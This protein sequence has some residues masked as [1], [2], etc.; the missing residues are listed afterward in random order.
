MFL[1]DELVATLREAKSGALQLV[2]AEDVLD[3]HRGLPL[4]SCSLPVLNKPQDAKNFLDGVLP[5]GAFRAQLA[6]NAGVLATD[7]FGLLNRY[8]RDIAGAIS[9]EAT[10]AA[11]RTGRQSLLELDDD[12]LAA[13]VMAIPDQPLGIHDDSE[14]S[15]AGLQNKLLLVKHGDRWARPVGGMA[16]THI[17]KLDSQSHPGVV[18]AEAEVMGLAKAVG[19]TTVEVERMTIGGIECIAVERFDRTVRADGVVKRIHQEDVCQAL[20][21]PPERK[22]EL[23]GRGRPGHGGGPEFSNVASLLDTYAANAA[24]DLDTLARIAVFTALT[25]NS[26]AH[27]KNLAVLHVGKGRVDL[28]PLYD[29]VPT[30]LFPRLKDEAAM[31]IGGTVDLA[32]VGQAALRR[33]ARH[34]SVDVDRM[35]DQGVQLAQMVLAA[36]EHLDPHSAVRQLVHERAER[37]L[38]DE[39]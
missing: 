18:A 14:L 29:T 38:A 34:W 39:K 1:G 10:G 8:G 21:Y 28:A 22:Y 13:E 23:P 19:L 24:R 17:V 3:R 2:Y 27:G 30:I 6:A 12:A 32:L 11:S 20:G 16:S 36:S 26:D 25:G 5:E 4:L 7:T 33:E 37:F 35:V 31:T 15:I 9:V